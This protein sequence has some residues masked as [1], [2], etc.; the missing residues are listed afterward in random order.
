MRI[1]NCGALKPTIRV[2]VEGFNT[3]TYNII[4]KKKSISYIETRLII[5]ND[6]ITTKTLIRS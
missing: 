4:D 3:V 6:Y 1:L 5:E 2:A